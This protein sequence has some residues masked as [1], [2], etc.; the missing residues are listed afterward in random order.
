MQD[1]FFCALEPVLLHWKYPNN[2]D[3]NLLFI[4]KASEKMFCR[5]LSV[6]IKMK[7]IRL[8]PVLLALRG[9]KPGLTKLVLILRF[10]F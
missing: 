8:I 6:N 9:Q 5:Q 2:L 1:R 7:N 4:I 10:L 3:R